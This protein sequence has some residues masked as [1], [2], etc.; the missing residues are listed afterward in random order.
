MSVEGKSVG[1]L[2]GCRESKLILGLGRLLG[3]GM[4]DHVGVS[5]E[6]FVQYFGV[7]LYYI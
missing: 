2:S 4:E 6:E 3:M 1:V 7:F 5:F